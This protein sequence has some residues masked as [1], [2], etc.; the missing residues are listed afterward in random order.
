MDCCEILLPD[1]SPED[2]EC[3]RAS[4]HEALA[5]YGAGLG[6]SLVGVVPVNG[7]SYENG[8]EG[9]GSPDTDVG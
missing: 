2:K 5:A 3:A 8:G 6:E 4:V 1:A 7:K 9:L